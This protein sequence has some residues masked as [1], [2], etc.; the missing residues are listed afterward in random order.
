[1]R[2]WFIVVCFYFLL[3]YIYVVQPAQAG[4]PILQWSKWGIYDYRG[5]DQGLGWCGY[6]SRGILSLEACAVVMM[7]EFIFT[8]CPYSYRLRYKWNYTG[9]LLYVYEYL[10]WIV[11]GHKKQMCWNCWDITLSWSTVDNG[12]S[13]CSGAGTIP[14]YA[15]VPSTHCISATPI[16][17]NGSFPGMLVEKVLKS[18]CVQVLMAPENG[19]CLTARATVNPAAGWA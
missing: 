13:L 7:Q 14:P 4:Q 19:G 1:M 9:W 6:V 5:L 2:E 12:A 15:S 10:W 16:C 17:A 8:M 3:F 18:L 11:Y